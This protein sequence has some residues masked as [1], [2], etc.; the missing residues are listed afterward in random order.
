M[1]FLFYFY[2]SYPIAEGNRVPLQYMDGVDDSDYI[3]AVFVHVGTTIRHISLRF[4]T[5]Y[6]LRH[7]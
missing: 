3:N 6:A 2:S 5:H 1:Q 7:I 4:T